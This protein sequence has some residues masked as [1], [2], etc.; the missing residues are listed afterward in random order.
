MFIYQWKIWSYLNGHPV[1][2]QWIQNE[3]MQWE[4][5]GSAASDFFVKYFTVR[6]FCPIHPAKYSYSRCANVPCAAHSLHCRVTIQAVTQV[7]L[8][9]KQRLRFSI[10]G[11]Y[12]YAI[13]V[14][15]SSKPREQPQ[16]SPCRDNLV[17]GPV[18]SW[19][20]KVEFKSNVTSVQS[21]ISARSNII[22][23]PAHQLGFQDLPR[24]AEVSGG[25]RWS[26]AT[27]R[28]G[29]PASASSWSPRSRTT[30]AVNTEITHYAQTWTKGRYLDYG[31]TR[32]GGPIT[33]T[34]KGGCVILT[35]TMR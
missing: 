19:L 25:W 13:F 26:R 20:T 7:L 34:K 6:T 9:L 35:V 1:L 27:T 5:W 14:F 21:Q 24:L 29:G 3:C 23:V 22:L 12:W 2:Q 30:R 16:W 31:C 10:R 28:Y 32:G 33:D 4:R 8:T 17:F 18:Y 15:M 11:M